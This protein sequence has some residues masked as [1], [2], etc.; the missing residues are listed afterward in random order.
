MTVP[1]TSVAS[2]RWAVSKRDRTDGRHRSRPERRPR[3]ARGI[4]DD[5]TAPK[6]PASLARI[7]APRLAAA[8]MAQMFD[9][10]SDRAR[11]ARDP[12]Q[13]SERLHEAGDTSEMS[14]LPR[15]TDPL[16]P[17]QVVGG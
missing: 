14:T 16:A 17:A 3:R 10:F 1:S 5:E 2:A 11:R 12:S 9:H 15:T 6:L 4:L 8:E 13:R 7:G